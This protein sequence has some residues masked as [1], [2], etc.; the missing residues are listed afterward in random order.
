[1]D[2]TFCSDCVSQSTDENAGDTSTYNLCGTIF[3]GGSQRCPT[4]GSRIRTLWGVF[5]ALPFLPLDSYR[6][7][8]VE[9]ILWGLGGGKYYSRRVPLQV[10][11]IVWTWLIAVA[12]ATAL[13]AVWVFN[14]EEHAPEASVGICLLGPSLLVSLLLAS[15]VIRFAGG[16]LWW[17]VYGLSLIGIFVGLIYAVWWE[18]DFGNQ[19]VEIRTA[20][21]LAAPLVL[22]ALPGVIYVRC[23]HPSRK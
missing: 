1:M 19:P 3:Y 10:G 22:V 4:C 5:L 16:C 12:I 11:Q 17:P 18:L 8:D 14:C 21:A 9:T 13:V 7:I 15:I 23:F 2:P 20:A 6:V